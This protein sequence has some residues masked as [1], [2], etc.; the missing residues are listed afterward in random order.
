[1]EGGAPPPFGMFCGD[2]PFEMKGGACE[3]GPPCGG[4]WKPA[5]GG[6]KAWAACWFG[7]NGGGT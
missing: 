7:T 6:E 5:G 3:Y 4:M 2:G 1:M